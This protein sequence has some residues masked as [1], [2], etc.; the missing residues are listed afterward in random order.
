MHCWSMIAHLGFGSK[1]GFAYHHLVFAWGCVD[2]VPSTQQHWDLLSSS[3]LCVPHHPVVSCLFHPTSTCRRSWCVRHSTITS[4][5][6]KTHMLKKCFQSS[7]ANKGFIS[8]LAPGL[9]WTHCLS[10]LSF[11]GTKTKGRGAFVKLDWRVFLPEM[12]SHCVRRAVCNDTASAAHV[13]GEQWE[14]VRLQSLAVAVAVAVSSIHARMPMHCLCSCCSTCTHI[15]VFMLHHFEYKLLSARTWQSLS[16]LTCLRASL[17]CWALRLRDCVREP[18]QLVLRE[19][20]GWCNDSLLLN[21]RLLN[22]LKPTICR[23]TRFKLSLGA[24]AVQHAMRQS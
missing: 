9:F 24:A 12:E 6:Y 15:H 7:G 20:R 10:K 21:A 3:S 17:F 23:R 16:G 22:M 19:L 2:I 1:R 4:Q 13:Q 8:A 5:Q 11:A 18:Q 14:S